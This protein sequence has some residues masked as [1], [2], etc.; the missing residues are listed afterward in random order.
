MSIVRL[1]VFSLPLSLSLSLSFLSSFTFS[2]TFTRS[3]ALPFNFTSHSRLPSHLSA[4]FVFAIVIGV[5]LPWEVDKRDTTAKDTSHLAS[6][7]PKMINLDDITEDGGVVPDRSSLSD[8]HSSMGGLAEMSSV[9]HHQTSNFAA[10]LPD[11]SNMEQDYIHGKPF[12]R[13]VLSPC[14]IC[15]LDSSLPRRPRWRQK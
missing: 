12:R 6:Q 11:F 3:T 5:P 8:A 1:P 15:R 4:P 14:V 10:I 9:P 7:K 13:R 2:Y